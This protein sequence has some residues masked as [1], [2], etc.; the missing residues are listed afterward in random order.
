MP[1]IIMIAIQYKISGGDESGGGEDTNERMDV[2]GA[3]LVF[4]VRGDD[5][6]RF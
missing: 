4:D 5:D 2:I 3:H 6:E 1:C